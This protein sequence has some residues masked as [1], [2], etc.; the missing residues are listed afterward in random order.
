MRMKQHTFFTFPACLFFLWTNALVAFG[1]NQQD[2]PLVPKLHNYQIINY[3]K[4]RDV[5]TIPVSEIES[6]MIEGEKTFINYS[7][8]AS[9][10]HPNYRQLVDNYNE[11]VASK[12]GNLIFREK[13]YGIYNVKKMNEDLWVIVEGYNDG[14]DYS[15]TV[16]ESGPLQE[17]DTQTLL[18]ELIGGNITLHIN[19][20]SGK[21]DLPAEALP[22]LKRIAKL[23]KKFPRFVI[24][25]EGH[26]DNVGS[27][28]DNKRLSEE[29]ARSIVKAL[30]QE[31]IQEMRMTAIGWGSSKP[32]TSNDTP[33]GREQNRRVEIVK[34]N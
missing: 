19:F 22:D 14:K 10:M 26:T 31:G 4:N 20:A 23:M 3:E 17:D 9:G 15:V 30:A 12:G 8:A 7:F 34:V 16:V 5:L 13:N 2:H 6:V 27:Q 21:S 1:Q 32:V 29:R 18:R 33:Q 24:S 25:I 28:T 11:I